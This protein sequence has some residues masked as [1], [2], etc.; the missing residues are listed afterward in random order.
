[1]NSIPQSSVA[2]HLRIVEITSA[3]DLRHPAVAP[4]FPCHWG[5]G[6]CFAFALQ[7]SKDRGPG[8]VPMESNLWGSKHGG[9]PLAI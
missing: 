6:F 3:A 9:Y 5:G 7:R 8:K 1:M 2:N 4:C